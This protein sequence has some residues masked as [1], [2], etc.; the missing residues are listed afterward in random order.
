[1]PRFMTHF[2]SNERHLLQRWG[3]AWHYQSARGTLIA[4]NDIDTWTLHNRFP[5]GET[6]G[7]QS[8]RDSLQFRRSPINHHILV[9][10]PWSPHLLVAAAYRL[11][12]V[13]LVG[14][15]AHQYIPTGGYGMNTGIGDAFDL[16]WKLAAVFSGFADPRLL[17][18]T[19]WI[20]ARMVC[21]TGKR[22][23]FITRCEERSAGC[24]VRALKRRARRA[25][26]CGPR[27][28]IAS[29]IMAMRKMNAA[30]IEFGY[31][32]EGSPVICS[33]PDAH[34]GTDFVGYQPTT[35]PGCRLPSTF[36]ARRERLVRSARPLVY[37][38]SF[39]RRR[40]LV[41]I[42]GSAETRYAALLCRARRTGP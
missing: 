29:Q 14:D 11:G 5:P 33:E 2:R 20:G 19:S 4:Q 42:I 17:S 18:H 12:R 9:A 32:Y 10:N 3:I 24:V 34:A 6:E 26:G 27:S 30:G 39:R 22:Q 15:A 40:S 25:T 41:A 8:E 35:I 1:M 16:G 28:G 13:L 31:S 38:N 36:F 21:A 7:S 23:R 37:A